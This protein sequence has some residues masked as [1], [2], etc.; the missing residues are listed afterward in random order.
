MIKS[1]RV[2]NAS[3]GKRLLTIL[4]DMLSWAIITV[5]VYFAILYSVMNPIFKYSYNKNYYKQVEAEYGL[6]LP[7][8]LAYDKYE[9]VLQHFYLIDYP[10]EIKK[11]INEHYGTNYS[12]VHIYNV[13]VL[14]LPDI[15]TIDK[16]Q[17]EFYAY[18]MDSE[19]HFLVDELAVLA[20]GHSGPVYEKTMRDL[21]YTSY[22]RLNT[23]LA[24]YHHD[25]GQ[26]IKNINTS[27]LI[28]RSVSISLSFVVLFVIVPLINKHGST[29]FEKVYRIGHVNYS[30]GY[31]VSKYKIVLEA[32]VNN[33]LV[34]LGLIIFNR[35]SI[36]LISV[37]FFFINIVTMLL[38]HDNRNI[39]E[40]L[41]KTL[42]IN[43]DNSLIF[44][45]RKEEKEYEGSDDNKVVTEEEFLNKL[46]S[47]KNI[48]SSEEK[49]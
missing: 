48:S 49:D 35:Y 19:G 44:D 38:S 6:N 23:M 28:S 29:V 15:P 12:I 4:F 40:L 2:E 31:S 1:L 24:S 22:S 16:Y 41:F 26:A 3:T 5:A 33:A 36:I 47:I 10:E 20:E 9:A 13:V 25:Y 46:E 11:E 32:L 21:F 42:T 18:K 17:T 8:G 7:V 45:N 39:G 14:Q 37:L 34:I 43:I 30:S 27:E